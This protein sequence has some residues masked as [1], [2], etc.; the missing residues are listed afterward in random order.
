M[1]SLGALVSGDA[2]E[3]PLLTVFFTEK[4]LLKNLFQLELLQTIVL[5]YLLEIYIQRYCINVQKL[6][7]IL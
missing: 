4:M 6:A 2:L 5:Q 7:Y 1:Q 3:L